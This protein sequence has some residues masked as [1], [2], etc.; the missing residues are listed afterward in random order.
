MTIG[1]LAIVVIGVAGTLPIY[2]DPNELDATTVTG[3]VVPGLGPPIYMAALAFFL[4]PKRFK[5]IASQG[6]KR[7]VQF[8][9]PYFWGFALGVVYQLSTQ[10]PENCAPSKILQNCRAPAAS[11]NN[12][13]LCGNYETYFDCI[14]TNYCWTNEIKS[15]CQQVQDDLSCTSASL[16]CHDSIS[17][18]QTLVDLSGFDMGKGRYKNLLGINAISAIGALCLFLFATSDDVLEYRFPED[19]SAYDEDGMEGNGIEMKKGELI[20]KADEEAKA[21]SV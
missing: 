21:S 1:R 10:K 19:F 9:L 13:T 20:G 2:A 7:P 4:F 18:Y 17:E 11:L 15:E 6:D 3:T 12:S 8:L 5:R 16:G 14:R